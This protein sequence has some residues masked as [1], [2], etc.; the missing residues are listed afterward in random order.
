MCPADTEDKI[1]LKCKTHC[2][3]LLIFRDS[4]KE[5]Y[6]F[7]INILSFFFYREVW[8]ETFW[9]IQSYCVL[10]IQ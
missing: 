10:Q 5:N 8:N 6:T 3:M 4:S 9:I 7:Y 2:V 1:V